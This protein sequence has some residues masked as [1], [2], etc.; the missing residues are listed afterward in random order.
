MRALELDGTRAW[1]AEKDAF[2][3]AESS[4]DF[5]IAWQGGRTGRGGEGLSLATLEG[6][7]RVILQSMTIEGLANALKKAQGGDKEGVTGGLFSTRQGWRP[8][9]R[10]LAPGM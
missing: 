10:D 3:A 4:V 8:K 9:V 6:N 2:V 7:G 1:F 5:G